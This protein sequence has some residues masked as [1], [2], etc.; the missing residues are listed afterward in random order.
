MRPIKVKLF[1]LIIFIAL[2]I[3]T[4]AQTCTGSLGDPVINQDFGSGTNPGSPLAAGVTTLTYVS[5]NCPND[6]E[7]TISNNISGA[8][9]CHSTWQNVTSNHSGNPNGYMMIVN[10][11]Y[12]PSI[13]F[14]Q[15]AS[16]LCPNT[17]YEFSSYILNLITLAASGPDVSEPN[18]TFSIATTLGQILAINSTGIIPPTAGPTWNKYGMYF[19]TPANVTNVVVTMTNNAP[20]GN[21]ND[22]ILDDITF[23]A[24]GPIIQTGFASITGATEKELCQGSNAITP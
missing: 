23:R 1:L 24:C 5:S 21:G 14:T 22:L 2:T 16:G 8:N 13:F 18:I 19:T 20:G 3:K 7:Y 9:N 10:A 15:T 12:Q 6:G 4:K 17:T 11:S